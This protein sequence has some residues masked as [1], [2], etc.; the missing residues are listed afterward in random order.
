VSRSWDVVFALTYGLLRLVDP[1][2][3]AYWTRAG[4]GNVVELVVPG[5]R[6]GRSRSVL[7]GLLRVEDRW[8]LGHPN[9]NAAWTA[10]LDA[11]STARLRIHG[12]DPIA[13]RA[14]LLSPGREREAAVRATWSQH[15]FPGGLLYSLA[16]DHVRARGRYFR[17]LPLEAAPPG[18]RDGAASASP[19]IG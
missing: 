17:I 4:L 12:L 11:A 13:V 9:G 2:I 7:V 3:R 6:T 15:P 18:E 5:R 16:R 10:N 8:Y 19:G 14:R 1:I